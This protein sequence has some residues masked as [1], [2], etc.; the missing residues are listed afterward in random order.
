MARA[1]RTDRAEAR[2]KYRAYVEAQAQAG[3][4]EDEG[5]D[6][7]AG[8]GRKP[9][10]RVLQDTAQL[11]P[12]ARMGMLQAAKA[13]YHTPTYISDIKYAPKLITKTHAIWPVLAMCVAIA[14]FMAPQLSNYRNDTTQQTLVQFIFWPPLVPAMLAGFLAPRATWLAG[15]IAAFI[16]TSTLVFLVF[17]GGNALMTTG[18]GT[19]P[20]P[21]LSTSPATSLVAEASASSSI[22]ETSTPTLAVTATPESTA[23]AGSSASVA[24]T[25]TPSATAAP[26]ASASPG[27]SPSGSTTT[28]GGTT[29]VADA[30]TVGLFALLQSLI[31]GA[32]IGGLSGWYKRFLSLTSGPR[33]PPSKSGGSRPAQR[34]RPATARK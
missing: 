33:K 1:K 27:A 5:S 17:L 19:T 7:S 31:L 4:A 29:A 8:S 23:S 14:A 34:R 25:A 6:G 28:G 21:S 30:L 15:L 20:T 3:I 9:A 16:A 22:L 12:G 26:G 18:A 2:R 13:A 24:P 11:Q 32:L 10:R